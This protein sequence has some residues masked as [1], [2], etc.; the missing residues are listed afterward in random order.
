MWRNVVLLALAAPLVA[1]EPDGAIA[2]PLRW[3]DPNGTPAGTRRSNCLPLT[4][5]VEEAWNIKLP[6]PAASPVVYWEGEAYLA[7]RHNE[8]YVLLAVDVFAG[9][10]V[11]QKTLP[12]AAPPPLPVVWDGRVYLRVAPTDLAELK[13]ANR[14][15]NRVWVH[16]PAE[17]FLSD[18]IIYENEI[19][20]VADG[21]L[22]RLQPRRRS[23]VWTVGNGALRGR[24]A[25]YG[26]RVY[27]LG[28]STQPGSAP[29]MHVFVYERRGGRGVTF[30]NAAWYDKRDPPHRSIPGGITVTRNT[31][32]VRGPAALATTQGGAT[33]VMLDHLATDK[34]FRL[35]AEA[36]GLM[37]YPVEPAVTPLGVLVL[38]QAQ[39]TGWAFL[40]PERRYQ[41]FAT[42][43]DNPDLFE[44]AVRVG[45]T[46]L[47]DIVYFG[48]WAA[49]LRTRHVLWRLP[50]TQL[51]YP[52][53]P[54]DRM[55]LV[56]DR[57]RFLRAFRGRGT[58]S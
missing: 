36:P 9:R 20:A 46:V 51:S 35:G 58:R 40:R 39:S 41:V 42:D 21:N 50:V 26:K 48:A 56:V 10:I 14:T 1:G 19:Y 6:G 15:F 57:H 54:L 45:P 47:G 28:E 30:K 8:K 52:A 11:A 16:K 31:V 53:V 25:L 44:P 2:H 18:P 55:V 22:I 12:K 17:E 32:I 27:A 3:C 7:C 4:R 37:N 29:S 5:D 43:E 33:H 23:P 38:A 49:D 34:R 24:P 13:R